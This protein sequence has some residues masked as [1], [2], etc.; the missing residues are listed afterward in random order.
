VNEKS[1]L[2]SEV[3]KTTF[4]KPEYQIPVMEVELNFHYEPLSERVLQTSYQCLTSEF[5]CLID[6]KAIFSWE[7]SLHMYVYDC[8][9]QILLLTGTLRGMLWR[10]AKTT[11]LTHH[12]MITQ[13]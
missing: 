2:Q 7:I 5:Q 1:L 6:E 10:R 11:F 13:E 12:A 8:Q 9:S 4:E 3:G